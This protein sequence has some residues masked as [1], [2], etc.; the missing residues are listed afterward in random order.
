MLK[1]LCLMKMS[2]FTKMKK[3]ASATLY[4]FKKL[5]FKYVRKEI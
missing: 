2:K 3:N 1:S 5:K 4:Q